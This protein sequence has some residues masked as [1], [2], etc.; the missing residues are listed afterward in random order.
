MLR[1][2]KKNVIWIILQIKILTFAFY[3]KAHGP[4]PRYSKIMTK[5]QNLVLILQS[6]KDT[7]GTNLSLNE[8]IAYTL[9]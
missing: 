2:E 1:S 3:A 4:N 5:K 8:T 9:L 6:L 7:D